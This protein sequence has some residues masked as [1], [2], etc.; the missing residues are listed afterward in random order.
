MKTILSALVTS[1]LLFHT[2]ARAADLGDPAAPLKIAKWV[3]GEPVE[4]GKDAKQI[5]VVEFWAT[6]CPPCRTSIPHLTEVQKHFKDQNV[7]IVGVTDEKE[8]TVKP[9]V[10]GLG[11]KMDYRVA[12]D[13]GDTANGYMK[14]YGINGIPHAFIVQDQ[15][16]IWHGHPMAGLDKTLAQV[17][18]GKYDLAKAKAALKAESLYN[19]FRQAA[20][21]GDDEKAD[22]IAAQISAAVK[23][24]SFTREFDADKEK[25]FMRT[26][27]LRNKFMNA[28]SRGESEKAA[29]YAKELQALDPS[30]DVKKLRDEVAMHKSAQAYFEAISGEN[31]SADT[32]KLASEL[33]P[34]LKNNPEI[35]N[36]IAWAIL[37]DNSI[38]KQDFEFAAKVAKQAVEDTN[39][40]APHIIDTYARA[41]FES[42]K[43][44]EAIAAEEKAL[45]LAS[46]SEKAQYER[47]LKSY[48]EGKAPKSE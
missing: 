38:K 28:E 3:K 33:E 15:K 9:F 43:K 31:E 8:S 18:A 26:S 35:A 30:I 32:K 20:A 27:M 7:T 13:E 39:W 42:G 5:Y 34:K 1:T 2:V 17:V 45:A 29:E 46:D 37:T 16:V 25:K 4:I 36:N 23:D 19:D 14:A 24:G 12:I 41:L 6:W 10:D 48:K 47:T 40:K 44:D 22:K 11:E 21:E